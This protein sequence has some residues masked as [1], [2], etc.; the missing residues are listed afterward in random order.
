M[1]DIKEITKS[2]LEHYIDYTSSIDFDLVARSSFFSLHENLLTLSENCVTEIKEK[3]SK[4]DVDKQNKYLKFVKS[5]IEYN[6]K[7][8]NTDKILSPY[9]KEY[10][11]SI[12]NFP[13]EGNKEVKQIL[14]VEFSEVKDY[15]SL[16]V[17]DIKDMHVNFFEYAI[18]IENYKILDV[19][20]EELFK[21]YIFN[22]SIANKKFEDLLEFMDMKHPKIRG[23]QAKIASIWAYDDS[24]KLFFKSSVERK[25]YLGYINSVY[26]TSYETR[27]ISSGDYNTH[28]IKDWLEA[29]S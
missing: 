14:S 19:V 1:L 21:F 10:D 29:N 27:T 12:N 22:S 25:D 26:G 23:N 2:N 4:L 18:Y 24:R 28:K 9:L 3:H 6:L 17:T 13:F 20:N 7:F 8:T 15:S 5:E 11:L 16:N